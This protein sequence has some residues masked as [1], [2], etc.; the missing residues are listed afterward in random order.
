MNRSFVEKL[1]NASPASLV[2]AAQRR[3]SPKHG[4][5]WFEVRGGPLK[6]VEILL[7]GQ[8]DAW[9]EMIAGTFDHFI[10]DQLTH[11]GALQN[12]V[13]WDVGAHFGYHS[14]AFAQLG[15][16]V[17]AFEPNSAN[18]DV[19]NQ[20]LKRNPRLA[21]R[22]QTCTTALSN[23]DGATTFNASLSIDGSSSGSHLANAQTPYSAETVAQFQQVTVRAARAD[24][25]VRTKELPPPDYIKVD[26]EGAEA[27]VL[28][29]ATQL[30]KEHRPTL[31]IEVHHICVMCD[32][33]VILD[34]AGYSV[35]ILD[36][37]Q[38]SPSR[39]FI[40]AYPQRA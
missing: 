4:Q 24:S 30:L 19:L 2:R 1:W 9:G 7:P 17:K 21:A 23:A 26:V 36:R 28:Q 18:L 13:I 33:R 25:I 34:N 38:A 39:C 40:Y 31:F 32:L 11:C 15:A 22:I 29:G 6:G 16:T 20:N 3:L 27:M 12:K 35:E 5:Q 14:L 8:T 10:Y 37:D